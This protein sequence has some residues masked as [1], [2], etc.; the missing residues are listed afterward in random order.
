MSKHPGDYKD[1]GDILFLN[2][3]SGYINAHFIILQIVYM[4]LN[5]IIYTFH[6]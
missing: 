1:T 4:C 3:S 6:I 5:F 2:L